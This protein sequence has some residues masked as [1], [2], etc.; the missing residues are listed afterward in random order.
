MTKE[1]RKL[2]KISEMRQN[3]LNYIQRGVEIQKIRGAS[4]VKRPRNEIDRILLPQEI[5][6]WGFH[7]PFKWLNKFLNWL[8]LKF[9]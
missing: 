3:G 8:W 4:F 1:K 2:Y 9:R 6:A 5:E 7:T